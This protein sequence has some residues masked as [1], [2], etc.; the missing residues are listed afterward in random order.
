MVDRAA[1]PAD[2]DAEAHAREIAELMAAP[3]KAPPAII[4]LGD[5]V[6]A[7]ITPPPMRD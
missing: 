6:V 1:T 5:D 3:V 4:V 7:G 2:S